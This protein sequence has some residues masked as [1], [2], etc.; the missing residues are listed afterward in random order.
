VSKSPQYESALSHGSRGF[1]VSPLLPDR[2]TPPRD[3]NFKERATSEARQIDAWW[4]A[5]C[6]TANVGVY[7]G[8]Y[9]QEALA[10][11]DI[12]VRPG[13]DGW[14]TIKALEA[15][16]SD[17]PDTYQVDTPSG[18]RHAY[19]TVP[20]PLR[21]GVEK[22]GPG[23]DLKSHGGYV[24]GAGSVI[25]DKTYTVADDRPPVAAPQWIIDRCGFADDR[26]LQQAQAQILGDETTA[27]IERASRY[28]LNDAPL[29]IEGQGGDAQTY[30]VSC[31]LKDFGLSE[32]AALDAMAQHWND[33][34]SPP[35]GVDDLAAKVKH[36]FRYGF[37]QPG[38]ADPAKA[39]GPVAE[40]SDTTPTKPRFKVRRAGDVKPQLDGIWLVNKLI[41]ENAIAALASVPNRMKTF[42]A[43]DLLMSCARGCLFADRETEKRANFY[44]D[45]D[46]DITNRVAGYLKANNL[47]SSDLPFHF[48]VD[49]IDLFGSGDVSHVVD[50]LNTLTQQSGLKPG[51]ACFDTLQGVF[52]GGDENSNKDINNL[53]GKFRQIKDQTGYTILFL[54]HLGKDATRGMRGHSG[55]EGKVDTVL[56][57]DDK[58][59][60]TVHKQRSGAKGDQFGFELQE[61]VLGQD[62]KGREVTTCV[63]RSLSAAAKKAFTRKAPKPGTVNDKA[64]KVLA[65]LIAGATDGN[66]DLDTF[67]RG[68]RVDVWRHE[69]I[70][71][72]YLTKGMTHK[73]GDQAFDRAQLALLAD[74]NI[75]QEDGYAAPVE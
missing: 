24:V 44:F 45:A 68:Y 47:D 34:C 33:R 38:A 18:G 9:G 74:G 65:S 26:V 23:V 36:A 70:S 67:S 71:A 14:E 59:I 39:F 49:A 50:A 7:C 43:V 72:H 19:Y 6:P 37:E 63:V 69:F 22:L 21:G 5:E 55:L 10:V 2:K 16:G 30:R 60:M 3:M 53:L 46:G 40:N 32:N 35:W 54:H 27:T 64:L 29:A 66:K 15:A 28:L 12:D 61:I 75:T 13:K 62:S 8:R 31:R 73:S 48:V 58:G 17:C 56:L 57:L 25:G 42:I 20:R 51:M 41:P 52:G 11:V 4:G 1:S